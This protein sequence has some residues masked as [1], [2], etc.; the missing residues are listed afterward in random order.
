M[1]F[2]EGEVCDCSWVGRV[3]IFLPELR[4]AAYNS[5]NII[6]FNPVRNNVPQTNLPVRIQRLQTTANTPD[7]DIPPILINP[8]DKLN[9]NIRK[10]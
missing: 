5:I 10:Q 8:R 7:A 2:W 9:S 4:G 1:V 3:V 6:K